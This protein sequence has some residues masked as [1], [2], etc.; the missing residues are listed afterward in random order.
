MSVSLE[1]GSLGWS[2][3]AGRRAD[4]DLARVDVGGLLDRETNGTGDGDRAYG[5]ASKGPHLVAT[6]LI[7]NSL[8]NSD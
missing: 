2:E 5:D 8:R 4:D 1:V 3:S 6:F 7:R